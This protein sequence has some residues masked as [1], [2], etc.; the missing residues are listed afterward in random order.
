MTDRQQQEEDSASLAAE[1]RALGNV[2][3]RVMFVVSSIS[4]VC[5]CVWMMSKGSH[6]PTHGPH[7]QSVEASSEVAQDHHA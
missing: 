2:I 7:T 1:W 6:S 5:L 3:D 4:L